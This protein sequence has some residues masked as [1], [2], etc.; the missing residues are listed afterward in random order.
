MTPDTDD[1]RRGN[2]VAAAMTRARRSGAAHAWTAAKDGTTNIPPPIAMPKRST[3][4]LTP[5]ADAANSHGE[6]CDPLVTPCALQASAS[7]NAAI[8]K[9]PIGTT[10]RL[11]LKWLA[12]AAR[13]E[14]TATPTANRTRQ[15]VKTVLGAA[16]D[17]ADEGRQHRERH[18]ADQPEPGNDQR[19]VP[20]TLL[21]LE[22]ADQRQG[23]SPRIAGD[24]EIGR[25]RAGGR[26]HARRQPAGD[27]D[28]H[29]DRRD[30][31]WRLVLA[32]GEAA[33]DRADEDGREGSGLDQRIACGKLLASSG[34]RAGCRI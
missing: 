4:I 31:R 29:D 2:D 13:P 15:S 11:G 32:G 28:R 20:Q 33:R 23:R 34:D 12:R 6:M 25:R 3:R 24:H 1:E 26:N 21:R 7:M 19:A 9:P 22:I 8:M 14:P 16:D 27:R 30:D 5:F 18:G 10:A 17:I